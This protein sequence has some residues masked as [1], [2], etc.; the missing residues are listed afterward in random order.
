MNKLF[1]NLSFWNE[2]PRVR[3]FPNACVLSANNNGATF[4]EK[5][6]IIRAKKQK[7][8]FV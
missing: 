7:L 3:N 4:D 6:F 5:Y 2:E 1:K 8:S